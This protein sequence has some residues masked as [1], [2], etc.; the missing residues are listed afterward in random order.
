MMNNLCDNLNFC[1]LGIFLFLS[2][3]YVAPR[4]QHIDINMLSTFL[5]TIC[6]KKESWNNSQ[7]SFEF[8]KYLYLLIYL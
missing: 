2:C 6:K 5:C 8:I 1:V 3:E 4:T 7:L